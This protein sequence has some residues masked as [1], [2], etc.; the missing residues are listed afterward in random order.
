M[1]H[2]LRI[3]RETCL[4]QEYQKQALNNYEPLSKKLKRLFYRRKKR[5]NNEGLKENG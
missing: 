4:R 1:D 2:F 3:I 5:K